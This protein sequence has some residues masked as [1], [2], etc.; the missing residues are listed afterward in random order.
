M[1]EEVYHPTVP[2]PGL[3]NL[4]ILLSVCKS[5]GVKYVHKDIFDYEFGNCFSLHGFTVTDQ[6]GR[7]P[8]LPVYIGDACHSLCRDIVSPTNHLMALA[9]QHSHLLNG[10]TLGVNIRRGNWSADSTQFAGS[11]D[12]KFYFCSDAGLEKF[13]QFIG[14][15]AG[16][17]Y[18][19]S[20]SPSTKR[21]IKGIFGDKVTMLDTEYTHSRTDGRDGPDG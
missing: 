7:G 4:L 20:D 19:T 13:K 12:P 11:T 9:A 21:H 6:E 15:T 5:N 14:N 18:V 10:V 1:D 8:H 3:G 16:R 17:V 2:K